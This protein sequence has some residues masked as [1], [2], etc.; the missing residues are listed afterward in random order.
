MNAVQLFLQAW[1]ALSHQAC[2]VMTIGAAGTPAKTVFGGPC[3][4]AILYAHQI[5]GGFWQLAS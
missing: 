1:N 2:V 5:I 4:D 3:T